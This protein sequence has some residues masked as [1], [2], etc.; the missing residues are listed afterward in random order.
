MPT[1]A[2]LWVEWIDSNSNPAD[3]LSRQELADPLFGAI[4]SV[5]SLPTWQSPTDFSLSLSD[6]SRFY[7]QVSLLDMTIVH[8]G[9]LRWELRV[10]AR[11][12][13]QLPAGT[14]VL[15]RA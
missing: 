14:F 8:V 3:G 10:S 15:Q 13:S 6:A 4:A 7:R 5:P 12:S 11:E 2:L 9:R 1:V